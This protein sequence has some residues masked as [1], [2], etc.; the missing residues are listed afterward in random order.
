MA[1]RRHRLQDLDQAL[2][3]QLAGSTAGRNELRESNLV[4]P[5]SRVAILRDH[6]RERTRRSTRRPASTAGFELMAAGRIG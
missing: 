3:V 2:S 4:H 5:V 1:K 6:I